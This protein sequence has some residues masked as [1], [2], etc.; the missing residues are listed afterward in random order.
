ILK[1]GLLTT[2]QD[3][4]RWGYQNDGVGIAGALD[5]FAFAAANL[6]VGNPEGAAGLEITL[7]G[8]AVK[9]RRENFFSVTGA[10]L[11]PRLDDRP[12]ALWTCH[13]APAGSVLTFPA[14]KNGVRAYLAVSGGI[15]VPP[16]MGS[17]S[18]Y[19]LGKFGGLEGRP[20]KAGDVLSA[21]AS[22]GAPGAAGNF[23][24]EDLRPPYRK[25]PT[26][27]TIRGPFEEFFLEEG[28]AAFYS[29]P[30]Q[31]TPQSDR[32]GFR[33]SGEPIRRKPEELITCGL[34][35]GTIQVPPNGQPILLLAD[36]QTI[37][38]YPIIATLIH[39]DIPL[40][41]QCAPGDRVRFQPVAVDEARQ[42]YLEMRGK[43]ETFRNS[44]C[45]P[46]S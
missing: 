39:A 36:R 35:S 21:G 43:L 37:G 30:Y 13:R 11:S 12:V 44:G 15:D 42:A 31:V 19:L 34:A 29:T 10:D 18:T 4:G 26:L 8:L 40:V 46:H 45:A 14:I 5:P 20:L 33:L 38:G 25:N 32:M 3:R 17:R 9:F 41:A 28:I 2:I 24:P 7:F 27:R 16:V 6:L 22:S 23:F 1:P